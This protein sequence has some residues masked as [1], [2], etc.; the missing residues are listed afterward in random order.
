MVTFSFSRYV[1]YYDARVDERW[2]VNNIL[3]YY[4]DYLSLTERK[5][6]KE[7]TFNIGSCN[8]LMDDHMR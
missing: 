3:D 5:T 1:D 8:Y 6:E 7:T 2:N 4:Y